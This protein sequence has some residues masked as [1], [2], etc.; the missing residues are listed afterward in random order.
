MSNI[1]N[2][3]AAFWC[4]YVFKSWGITSPRQMEI[5]RSIKAVF[6]DKDGYINRIID[7]YTD[8]KTKEL[9]KVLLE[10]TDLR[11]W[12]GYFSG[13]RSPSKKFLS[14]ID[15]LVPRSKFFFD[16]GPKSLFKILSEKDPKIAVQDLKDE[17]YLSLEN[18]ETESFE[19]E[20]FEITGIDPENPAEPDGYFTTREINEKDLDNISDSNWLDEYR[21][22]RLMLPSIN[23]FYCRFFTKLEL[24]AEAE[25][26]LEL[27]LDK[28]YIHI[29]SEVI[30]AKFL[31]DKDR[32]S[33]LADLLFVECQFNAIKIFELHQ[34][35][36]TTLWFNI[37]CIQSA[38]SW[39]E[40]YLKEIF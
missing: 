15:K 12:E 17:I 5:N 9:A 11:K 29:A 27:E 36:P 28:L 19:F 23:F 1:N 34:G 22:L 21:K 6:D 33:I 2:L 32:Y 16:Y 4:R 13:E 40:N 38:K 30:S 35:I 25:L 10:N 20:Y 31:T 14:E 18:S 26:E 7:S 8:K 39:H 37:E 3:K 24:E